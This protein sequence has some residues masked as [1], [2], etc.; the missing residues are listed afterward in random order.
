M[1]TIK[2]P[3]RRFKSIKY[4]ANRKGYTD[5]D[6]NFLKNLLLLNNMFPLLVENDFFENE[7]NRRKNIN[8]NILNKVN[9]LSEAIIIAKNYY[10]WLQ[11]FDLGSTSNGIRGLLSDFF[12]RC[13]KDEIYN[14]NKGE[15][16]SYAIDSG[17]RIMF[18]NLPNSSITLPDNS[19]AY[20]IDKIGGL[21]EKL[22]K[23]EF[24]KYFKVNPQEIARTFE[25]HNYNINSTYYA[26]EQKYFYNNIIDKNFQGGQYYRKR[27][28]RQPRKTRKPKKTQK[29]NYGYKLYK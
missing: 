28:T 17:L 14:F 5:K 16:L 18:P 10:L 13:S 4:Y 6:N 23:S 2:Q 27:K 26:L 20:S 1:A 15:H 22:V 7:F 9:N 19:D 11:L 29:N 21:V 12:K 24:S 25:A 3:V 8:F